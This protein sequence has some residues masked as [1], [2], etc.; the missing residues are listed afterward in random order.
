MICKHVLQHMPNRDIFSFIKLLPKFKYCLILEAA[1]EGEKNID[2]PVQDTF[3]FWEDRGIDITLSPFY[4]RGS[5][6][7]EYSQ[8]WNKSGLDRL[9]L[10][11]RYTGSTSNTPKFHSHYIRF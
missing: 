4:V 2:Y 3:P 7:L 9:I 5:R 11:R 8:P 6:V 1:P 10:I